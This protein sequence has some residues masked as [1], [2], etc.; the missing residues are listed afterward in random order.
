MH[1][2]GDTNRWL[3]V[4]L[5]KEINSSLFYYLRSGISLPQNDPLF[6][7][8]LNPNAKLMALLVIDDP[9]DAKQGLF[10]PIPSHYRKLFLCQVEYP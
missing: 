8:W 2:A 6:T 9:P 4:G 1:P 5:E 7:G 10:R 3:Y